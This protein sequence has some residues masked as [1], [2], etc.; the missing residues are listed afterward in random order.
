MKS[1]KY[2]ISPILVALI[3]FSSFSAFANNEI[4]VY[5]NGKRVMFDVK[6]QTINDRTMVPIRAIFEAMGAVVDW[7]S[8]T[9]TAIST[10]DN[11]TVKMALN[12]TTMYVNDAPVAMDVAPQIIDNRTLSPARYVAEAFGFT[13]NW[14]EGTRSV[15]ISNSDIA[16]TPSY[17]DGTRE[18]PYEFGDSVVID[19]LDSYEQYSEPA[20]YGQYELTL[21]SVLSPSDMAEKLNNSY[22]THDETRS[23]IYGS[24]KL[25]SYTGSDTCEFTNFQLSSNI[26]TSNMAPG[27]YYSWY[28]NPS[29][30]QFVELYAGGYTECYI[31]IQT[32]E[33][34]TG[35]TA[36]YFVLKYLTTDG[37][38]KALWFT[39]K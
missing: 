3:V 18:H 33:I 25:N 5:V 31:P 12:S 29:S 37:S 9:Q 7:D 14:D 2:F 17:R 38:E 26:V 4:S 15:L 32:D 28:M 8:N 11:T 10:K 22:Y 36:D 34:P 21:Y 16:F 6:P 24:V 39:I 1:I 23:Y 19:F 20:V 35:E 30:Y 13:V 27:S